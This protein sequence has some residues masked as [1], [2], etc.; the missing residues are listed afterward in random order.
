M[1]NGA[2]IPQQLSAKYLGLT[3]DS[4]LTWK[5]HI[6]G[7]TKLMKLKN[8]QMWWLL[9]RRS[10][11]STKNKLLL[12]KGIIKPAWIYGIELWGTAASSNLKKLERE[13]NSASNIK[14]AFLRAKHHD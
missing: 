2:A 9:Q 5:E 6:V 8:R 14:C 7:K 13:Q 3:L 12:Y 11:L 1:L 4:R 10:K